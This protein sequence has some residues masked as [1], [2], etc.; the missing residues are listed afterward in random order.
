MKAKNTQQEKK[1]TAALEN[2]RKEI[3]RENKA[4][5]DTLVRRS[6]LTKKVGQLKK[7]YGID[8]VDRARERVQ[9]KDIAAY[10]KRKS[11][12]S[13]LVRK[14]FRLVVDHSVSEQKRKR[15]K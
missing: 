3:D 2:L 6:A 12:S 13:T 5:V 14:I 1:A 15:K 7:R 11:V 10:A 9:K 8:T 4:L